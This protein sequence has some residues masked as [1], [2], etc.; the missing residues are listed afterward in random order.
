MATMPGVVMTRPRVLINFAVSLDGKINP[1]PG[2]RAGPFVMS[3]GKEDFQRMR[4]LRAQGDAILIGAANLRMDDPGLTL[5][6]DERERRRAAGR[7]LPA[8]IVVTRR[9]DGIRTDAK[10][11]DRSIGGPA[12]VVHPSIMPSGARAALSAVA[13]LVE[14]GTDV[15]PMDA[16]LAWM[17]DSLGAATVV[18]EGGGI[19]VA[20]LFAARA[21]DELYLTVVPRIL[22][23]AAAP[24][25][26]AGAGF[27][28]DQIAD[29]KLA[30]LERI[31]DEIYLRYEF[32]PSATAAI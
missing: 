2:H 13:E 14:I 26:V 5:A 16:L 31:G 11:F 29:A 1:A 15:V 3:R 32:P 25:L 20:D 30:S 18:C 9:G 21:V 23:G 4:L 12:Y 8:R 6:P 7:P 17:R 24:T 27:D 19:L 10:I 28:P 22:G